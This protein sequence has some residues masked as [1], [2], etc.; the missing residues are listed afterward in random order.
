MPG[1]KKS[2]LIFLIC[3]IASYNIMESN[4]GYIS[5]TRKP[6]QPIDYTSSAGSPPELVKKIHGTLTAQDMEDIL[7]KRNAA[8]TDKVTENSVNIIRK[9]LNEKKSACEVHTSDGFEGFEGFEV[10]KII[11]FKTIF[12]YYI[13][14]T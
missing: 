6:T 8:N 7:K 2:T 4:L 1:Y 3:G 10:L 13:K 5:C 9:Y 14:D 12:Y 11:C